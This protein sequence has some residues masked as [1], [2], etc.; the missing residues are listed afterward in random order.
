MDANE[1]QIGGSHYRKGGA[2]Q[3][4][5]FVEDN[6]LGYLEGCATKYVTRWRFKN[7]LQDLEKA[8]HYLDKLIET[9]RTRHRLPRGHA[10]ADG[11]CAF[12]EANS[13][14]DV[15]CRVVATLSTWNCPEDLNR[16]RRL[17]HDMIDA[18]QEYGF[19]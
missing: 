11:I 19:I 10:N 17:I 5:D 3:H 8:L 7:G 13:L 18:P 2:N 14:N 6:G 15:E 4:W 12:A 1:R 9:H 16:A